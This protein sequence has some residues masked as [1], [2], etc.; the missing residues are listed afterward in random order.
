MAEAKLE[1]AWEKVAVAEG[2]DGV[3]GRG[4]EDNGEDEVVEAEVP[5]AA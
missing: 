2:A 1:A 4:R 5:W 3:V